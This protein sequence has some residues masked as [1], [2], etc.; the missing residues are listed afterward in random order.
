MPRPQFS[1]I[2]GVVSAIMT[3][4]GSEHRQY[5]QA[6]TAQLLITANKMNCDCNLGIIASVVEAKMGLS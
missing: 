6:E 3:S 5:L 2:A 1:S 4:V